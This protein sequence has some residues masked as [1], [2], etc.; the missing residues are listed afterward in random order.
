MCVYK[1][2]RIKQDLSYMYPLDWLLQKVTR[3]SYG[4]TISMLC[5][6]L[7]KPH[8]SAEVIFLKDKNESWHSPIS[9]AFFAIQIKSKFLTKGSKVLLI[10]PLLTN[11]IL[12]SLIQQAPL[13]VDFES[14]SWMHLQACAYAKPCLEGLSLSLQQD[15]PLIRQIIASTLSPQE[16][17]PDH[18]SS[19][20]CPL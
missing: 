10:Y 20:R 17:V 14:V 8:T 13:H 6:L 12:C 3:V 4:L 19:S 2:L 18:C 5:I 7:L 1:N 15:Q 11:F 16:T 9:A